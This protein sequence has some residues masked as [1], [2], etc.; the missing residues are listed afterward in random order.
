MKTSIKL[1]TMITVVIS[2]FVECQTENNNKSTSNAALLLILNNNKQNQTTTNNSQP[3]N[4]NESVSSMSSEQIKATCNSVISSCNLSGN[5]AINLSNVC[6][7]SDTSKFASNYEAAMS[8]VA[9]PVS[10][11]FTK[12]GGT[13]L[14]CY[15]PAIQRTWPL[16]PY[17]WTAAFIC[18]LEEQQFNTS[19]YMYYQ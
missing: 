3:L 10:A 7:N 15:C 13:Y 1:I 11:S 12:R 18:A 8:N 19:C 9:T 14:V 6:N 2:L 5:T 17:F 4:F 16:G